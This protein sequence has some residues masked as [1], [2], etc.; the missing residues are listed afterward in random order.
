MPIYEYVCHDCGHEFEMLV[1]SEER[2]ACPSC[3]R[4][5]LTKRLSVPAAHVAASPADACP[6]RE[7]CP[8]QNCSGRGCGMAEWMG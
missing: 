7:S 8:S 6:V 5:K 3:G 4:K 2:P 1:R